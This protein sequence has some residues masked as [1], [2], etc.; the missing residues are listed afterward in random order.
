MQD[1]IILGFK[2]CN[3]TG[4]R[5]LLQ[6]KI[7]SFRIEKWKCMY[8]VLIKDRVQELDFGKGCV[9]MCSEYVIESLALLAC[10]DRKC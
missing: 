2:I 10:E 4:W 6:F 9:L 7:S 8:S 1:H 5:F 3:S